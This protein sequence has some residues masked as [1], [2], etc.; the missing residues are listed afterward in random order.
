MSSEPAAIS[1]LR[2]MSPPGLARLV[3][4]CLLK[5]AEER[6]QNMHD[7]LLEPK[8]IAEAGSEAAQAQVGM[9]RRKHRGLGWELAAFF[10]L[11]SL[12]V[13]VIA[14]RYADRATSGMEPIRAQISVP[15]GASV[16]MTGDLGGPVT[17][18]PDG[19]HLAF[20]AATGEGGVG[21]ALWVRSLDSFSARALP[22]TEGALFPFW[23]TDSRSIGFFADRKLK[24][25]AVSGGPALTVCD[26]PNPRGGTWSRDD[27]ILFAPTFNTGIH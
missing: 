14:V 7:V 12:S 1:E 25:I 18:S 4:T 3:K 17:I 8:W 20:A 22:G 13:G 15:E 21:R 6:C 26:A 2:P 27:V 23:S 10:L 11:I 16:R 19:R 9:Q 24:T 5:D